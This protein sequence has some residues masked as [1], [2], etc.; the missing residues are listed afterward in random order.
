MN[1]ELKQLYQESCDLI[2]PYLFLEGELGESSQKDLNSTEALAE[3]NKGIEGL[4]KV[5]KEAEYNWAAQW[6]LGKALQVLNDHE[7][8]HK[9]FLDAYHNN[10][11][12]E[13]IIRELALECLLTDRFKD[14]AY[15]C[16]VAS[17]FSPEDYTLWSN[18]SVAQLFNNNL[19]KA[20]EW[21]KKTLVK[22]PDD[23]PATEVLKYVNGIRDGTMTLPK[24]FSLFH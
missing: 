20:E 9:A 2:R 15:Y 21:A 19:E 3:L 11:E 16:N 10:L 4:K 23:K 13:A 22:I 14:A 6:F 8:A 5:I 24:K 7:N 17:E 12:H 18:I 1:N